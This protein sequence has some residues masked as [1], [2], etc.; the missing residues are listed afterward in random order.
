VINEV[1]AASRRPNEPIFS[2]QLNSAPLNFISAAEPRPS[3]T[4]E[5]RTAI[6]TPPTNGIVEFLADFNNSIIMERDDENHD[7]PQPNVSDEEPMDETDGAKAGADNVAPSN[8]AAPSNA[9][10]PPTRR[11]NS[12]RVAQIRK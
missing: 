7:V 2:V 11:F 4:V 3:I 6:S 9:A 5:V 10:G 1:V 12:F 8:V